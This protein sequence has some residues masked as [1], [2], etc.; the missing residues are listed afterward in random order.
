[1]TNTTVQNETDV[2]S[3][4]PMQ[5]HQKI[6]QLV[7]ELAPGGKFVLVNDHDPKPLYY[8][9]EA[10]HPQQFSW[11]YL[12]RGPEVWRVEIGRLLKAA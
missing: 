4:V 9:L 10:E 6:F 8:Q 7:D 1:M 5:R 11:T 2:R 3:L 12:E